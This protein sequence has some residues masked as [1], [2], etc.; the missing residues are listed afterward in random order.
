MS[1]LSKRIECGQV[2]REPG[3]RLGPGRASVHEGKAVKGSRKDEREGSV[4]STNKAPQG[5]SRGCRDWS[6]IGEPDRQQTLGAK[7]VNPKACAVKS[8]RRH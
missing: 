8:H 6:S 7:S 4:S 2:Q 3:R 1:I 5:M